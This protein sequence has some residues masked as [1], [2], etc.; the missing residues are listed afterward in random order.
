MALLTGSIYFRTMVPPVL[1]GLAP[2]L[3]ALLGT[4]L[5]PATLL[6]ETAVTLSKSDCRRLVEQFTGDAAAFQPGR[7]VTGR[8]VAPAERG[9]SELGDA[10]FDGSVRLAFPE[11]ITIEIEVE[12]QE[13]FGFPAEPDL[14]LTPGR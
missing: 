12:L 14:L 4:C 7:D 11:T 3:F 1:R 10:E 8:A 5:L 13:R 9:G 2:A 6:A